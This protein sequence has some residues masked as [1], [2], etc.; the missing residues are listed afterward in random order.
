PGHYVVTLVS[1][2]RRCSMRFKG[3]LFQVGTNHFLDMM[4]VLESCDHVA[5]GP[6]GPIEIMQSL[7]LQQLHLV[8]R[9]DFTGTGLRCG[10]VD[11]Q[12]LLTAADRFPQYFQA[13]K[14]GRI[15]RMV[16]NPKMEQDFLLRF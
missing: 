14:P 7:T 1:D 15:A 4:P 2:V 13:A 3:V 5:G 8:V 11:R 10:V 6:P 12:A 16:S 9:V